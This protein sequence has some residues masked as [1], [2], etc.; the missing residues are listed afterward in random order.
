MDVSENEN[1]VYIFYCLEHLNLEA[2]R[3]KIGNQP[4]IENPSYLKEKS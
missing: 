2:D 4:V 3:R 1:V